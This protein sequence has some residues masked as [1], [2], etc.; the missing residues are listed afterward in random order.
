MK[1]WHTLKQLRDQSH[2]HFQNLLHLL[3]DL[4]KTKKTNSCWDKV[5]LLTRQSHRTRYSL[6]QQ[7]K[8]WLMTSSAG[9]NKLLSH[10]SISLLVMCATCPQKSETAKRPR[11]KLYLA[12]PPSLWGTCSCHLSYCCFSY[13]FSNCCVFGSKLNKKSLSMS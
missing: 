2:Y 12:S 3:E 10:K 6:Q 1:Q 13:C 11:W 4:K 7:S 9:P 8:Y 5:T